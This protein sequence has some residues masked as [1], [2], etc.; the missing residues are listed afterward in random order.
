V[1]T[2]LLGR[3][4]VDQPRLALSYTVQENK[5]ATELASTEDLSYW[6]RGRN[7]KIVQRLS[8]S[9]SLSLSFLQFSSFSSKRSLYRILRPAAAIYRASPNRLQ[10]FK[11][12]PALIGRL[13]AGSANDELAKPL[14]RIVT[15]PTCCCRNKCQCCYVKECSKRGFGFRGLLYLGKLCLS[16]SVFLIRWHKIEYFRTQCQEIFIGV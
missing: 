16:C 15:P 1:G 12:F 14:A 11:Q 4:V 5:T 13:S 6:Y 9:F 7:W 2:A 3:L 8:R 10:S